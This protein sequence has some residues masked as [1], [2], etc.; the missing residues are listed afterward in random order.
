MKAIHLISILIATAVFATGCGDNSSNSTKTPATT[1]TDAKYDSGNPLTAAPDY[2]GAVVQAKKYSEKQIDLAYVTHAIQ[3]FQ[4]S[5]GRF[6]KDLQELVPD[7]IGK[8]P[9]AP[10]GSKITYDATTGTVKV[11]KQ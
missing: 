7:Y 1:N 5:E 2:V 4:A 9:V 11:V 6:P 10:L 8:V 3:M